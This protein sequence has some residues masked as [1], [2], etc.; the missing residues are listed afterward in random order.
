MGTWGQKAWFIVIFWRFRA[1]TWH[2]S[3]WALFSSLCL[4]WASALEAKN[5]PCALCC[6]FPLRLSQVTAAPY[7]SGSG[8]RSGPSV[9]PAL[10]VN[11]SSNSSLA[12]KQESP[13]FPRHHSGMYD[14]H[15]LAPKQARNKAGSAVP[16]LHNLHPWSDGAS[17]LPNWKCPE[18]A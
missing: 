13:V 11:P 4:I 3:S 16:S 15:Q 14:W 18:S 9:P 2:F 10:S 12:L 1:F 6:H 8:G 5:E 17:S 7:P